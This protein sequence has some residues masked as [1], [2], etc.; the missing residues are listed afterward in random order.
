MVKCRPLSFGATIWVCFL[1]FVL[2]T[3]PLLPCDISDSRVCL[4]PRFSFPQRYSPSE[5]AEKIRSML[6]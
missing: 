5:R 1:F 2:E 3:K 4:F 6:T